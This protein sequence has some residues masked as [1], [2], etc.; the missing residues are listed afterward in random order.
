MAYRRIDITLPR[1]DETSFEDLFADLKVIDIRSWRAGE[2]GRRSIELLTREDAIE[3]VLEKLANHFGESSDYRAE[4]IELSA[5]LPRPDEVEEEPANGQD[6]DEAHQHARNRISRDELLEDLLPGTHITRV[7]LLM[8]FLSSVIAAI[9]LVRNNTAVV[10]GAMVIAPLLLPN[11]SLSLGTTLGDLRMILRSL[12][13]NAAGVAVCLAFSATAGYLVEFDPSVQEIKLRTE[14]GY[15]DIALALAAG[16][17]GALAVTS[18]VSA[19]LIGVMVAV[20]LLPPMV[21]FGLLM[22][23]GRWELAANAGLLVAVNIACLN[24]AGVG[25]FLIRGVRPG[26]FYQQ[27]HARKAIGVAIAVWVLAVAAALVAIWFA[28]QRYQENRAAQDPPAAAA[29]ADA[30]PSDDEPDTDTPTPLPI[31]DTDSPVNAE[32][33]SPAEADGEGGAQSSEPSP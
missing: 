30:E 23:G 4:V 1:D 5:V 14:I 25:T 18:G 26:K 22:G 27:E 11:M 3:P 15:S 10:I 20:A 24:L 29:P 31:G 21:A 16:T 33:S 19:N 28:Q 9:G 17:A 2:S 13:A 12:A 7:Y 8:V 6:D 32:G